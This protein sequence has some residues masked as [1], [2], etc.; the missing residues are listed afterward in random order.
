[1][2]DWAPVDAVPAVDVTSGSPYTGAG[3]HATLSSLLHKL[4]TQES[5][6]Q[7]R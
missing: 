6:I 1:M 7:G 5:R 2:S 3:Q 4:G